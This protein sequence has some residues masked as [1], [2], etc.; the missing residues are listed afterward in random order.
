MQGVFKNELMFARP[1]EWLEWLTYPEEH[2][3]RGRDEAEQD[4]VALLPCSARLASS[5]HDLDGSSE[6]REAGVTVVLL[7]QIE[8]VSKRVDHQVAA[9]GVLRSDTAEPSNPARILPL[10]C[11]EL[12]D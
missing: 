3:C 1:T 10:F 6:R 7:L 4:F 11:E 9:D 8:R 12:R 5:D 2:P